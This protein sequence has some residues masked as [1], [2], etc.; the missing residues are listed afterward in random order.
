VNA[1]FLMPRICLLIVAVALSAALLAQT[2]GANSQGDHLERRVVSK[3]APFYPEVAK[4]NRIGGVVR[5]EVVVRKNG[6][7]KSAKV[8]GGSPLLVQSATDAICKWRFE[9]AS[10]ETTEV[11]Q[12][13]FQN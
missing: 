10:G 5:L 11:V 9:P 4:R 2:S 7:V 13:A 8:L 3:V 6:S 12:F 1:L